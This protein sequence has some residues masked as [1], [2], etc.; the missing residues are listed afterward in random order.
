M[1]PAMPIFL[2]Y[3][4]QPKDHTVSNNQVKVF[5]LQVHIGISPHYEKILTTKLKTKYLL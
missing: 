2:T 3:S 4:L 1:P 5:V